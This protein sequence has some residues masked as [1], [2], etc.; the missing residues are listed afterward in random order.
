M[1]YFFLLTSVFLIFSRFLYLDQDVPSYMISGICQEDESYY[2]NGALLR[3]YSDID[4][5]SI[6]FNKCASEVVKLYSI[7]FTY[8]TLHLFG[9]NYW[10]LRISIPF[11][12]IFIILLLS[13]MAYREIKKPSYSI[14]LS[15]LLLVDFYFFSFSRYFTPQFFSILILS[16]SIYAFFNTKQIKRQV[17]FVS[18]LSVSSVL[19]FYVYNVFF[20]FGA[21][22]Y[23]IILSIKEKKIHI[24]T[25]FILGSLFSLILFLIIIGFMGYD[26]TDYINFFVGFSEKRSPFSIS[27]NLSLINFL[28]SFFK[29][30]I[31]VFAS[32]LFRYNNI[33]LLFL[34]IEIFRRIL[35]IIK[36]GFSLTKNDFLFLVLL[37]AFIQA[38]FLN[39][40]PFKKWIVLLPIVFCLGIEFFKNINF[41]KWDYFTLVMLTLLSLYV[42]KINYSENYWSGLNYGY[43]S[44]LPFVFSIIPILVLVVFIFSIY[45]FKKKKIFDLILFI[46]PFFLFVLPINVFYTN[47][48]YEI[49]S[50]LTR[51]K[52][53]L[54]NQ[55]LVYGFP[56]AYS[57]YSNAIP[58]LNPYDLNYLKNSHNI[59]LLDSKKDKYGLIKVM[60]D[61]N[62]NQN[63]FNWKKNTLVDSISLTFYDLKLYKLE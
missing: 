23:Y 7:P 57:L 54:E 34:V 46:I 5:T 19:F 3:Y 1:K 62:Y 20:V 18:F 9:N 2:A 29:N 14:F 59:N 63:K 4:Q 61:T 32:N 12:S 37:F 43:Y 60:R 48:K 38:G 17:L 42:F 47:K 31:S 44:N 40:Y 15:L 24:I 56:H 8:L 33:W 35:C 39:S 50:A 16:L 41:S 51:L 6:Y 22:V 10:G 36:N 49:K 11:L 58:I 30:I 52:P 45:F 55:Y 26:I 13:S 25:Y 27:S 53:T 28:I 21:A